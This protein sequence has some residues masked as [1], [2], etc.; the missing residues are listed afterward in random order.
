MTRQIPLDLG[1]AP[2]YAA[3]DFLVSASNAAAFAWVERW[4]DWPTPH[5]A[6][7]GPPACGKTHL[8]HVWRTRAQAIMI[9]CGALAG[10][11]P[12]SLIGSSMTCAIDG[13]GAGPLAPEAERT[14]LHLHN[15]I[16]ERRGH[17]LLCA[18]TPPARWPVALPDLRSRL[19]AMSV[20]AIAPPDDGL[21]EALVAKLFADRQLV[22]DRGTIIYM[23]AHMER[24]FGAARHLVDA[25]DRAALA[26][27]RRPT[28]GLVR[29]VM[30]EIGTEM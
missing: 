21:L 26:T 4:P 7:W 16:A 9:D 29:D 8:T 11:S 17:L 25:I 24:S 20:V 19:A 6:L 30:G 23:V 5:L 12:T 13:F 28:L 15:M 3:G 2:S 10:A 27:R 22:L 1:F 18:Q 14:L